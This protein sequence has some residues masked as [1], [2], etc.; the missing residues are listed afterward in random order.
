MI[1]IKMN[2]PTNIIGDYNQTIKLLKELSIDKIQL[3]TPEKLITA[4][5]VA[6][7]LNILRHFYLKRLLDLCSGF[8]ELINTNHFKAA[9]V[10]GRA[11]M[12]TISNFYYII[13]KSNISLEKK[14]F[15]KLFELLSSYMLGGN[16]AGHHHENNLKLT[17]IHVNKGIE[18][19]AK[20]N[21]F[22]ET[23]YHAMCE[24]IHPN[25]SGLMLSYSRMN[26]ESNCVELLDKVPLEESGVYLTSVMMDMLAFKELWDKSYILEN[27]ILNEWVPNPDIGLKFN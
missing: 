25:S 13:E 24:L 11:I 18:E 3:A 15:P 4:T 27:R 8:D 26:K 6:S 19:M 5:N 9:I 12:E 20:A 17:S 10:I 16:K 14:E 22:F 7:T 23:R 2:D 21:P 1:T